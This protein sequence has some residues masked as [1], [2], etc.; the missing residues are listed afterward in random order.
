MRTPRSA[1][2]SRPSAASS[3]SR[4]GLRR[5]TTCAA[6]SGAGTSSRRSALGSERM[7]SVTSSLRNEG[8]S[9][10]NP[11]GWICP[12]ASSGTATVTPSRSL[13]GSKR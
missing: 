11:A 7:S 3:G 10:S 13:P 12:S 1:S 5:A 6:T 8:T 4:W 2:S 9:Q